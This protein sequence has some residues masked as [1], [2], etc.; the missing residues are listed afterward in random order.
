MC[1]GLSA[2]T[3]FTYALYADKNSEGLRQVKVADIRKFCAVFEDAVIRFARS[4]PHYKYV[5]TKVASDD[6]FDYLESD[7]AAVVRFDDVFLKIRDIKTEE[8]VAIERRYGND[9]I[10]IDALSEAKQ[11]IVG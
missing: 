2:R 8:V 9:K 10:V 7:D 3:V 6:I 5:F 4:K 11:A 1:V